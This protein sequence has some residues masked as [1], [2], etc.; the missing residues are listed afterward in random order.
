MGDTLTMGSGNADVYISY[1]DS[2][3][4]MDIVVMK[5]KSGWTAEQQVYSTTVSAGSGNLTITAG[6]E[7]GCYLRVYCKERTDGNYRA[8]TAPIWF[9]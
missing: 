7:P 9:N 1:A 4:S 3:D 2:Y 6:V 8:Y 5:G